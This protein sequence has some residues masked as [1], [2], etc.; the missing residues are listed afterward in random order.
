MSEPNE[1]YLYARH[2]FWRRGVEC[3]KGSDKL[4]DAHVVRMRN[5][6]RLTT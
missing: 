4:T 6:H 1:L 3:A 5:P 2:S